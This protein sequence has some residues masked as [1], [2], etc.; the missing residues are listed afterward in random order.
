MDSDSEDGSAG[1]GDYNTEDERRAQASG[2]ASPTPTPSRRRSSP[3][4]TVPASTPTVQ[5]TLPPTNPTSYYKITLTTLT[6]SDFDDSCCRDLRNIFIST[7]ASML[8]IETG[9]VSILSVSESGRRSGVS[10]TFSVTAESTA[11]TSLKGQLEETG[12]NGF[13]YHFITACENQGIV[14]SVSQS[15]VVQQVT[16]EP[17]PNQSGDSNTGLLIGVICAALFLVLLTIGIAFW[18]Y[19]QHTKTVLATGTNDHDQIELVES[20][21]GIQMNP[22]VPMLGHQTKGISSCCHSIS[23]PLYLTTTLSHY[24]SILRYHSF[25]HCHFGLDCRFHETEALSLS[26]CCLP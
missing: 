11:L 24:H 20:P 23:L 8:G 9:S 14:L 7:I 26:C 4:P 10:L 2:S 19:I 17:N 13:G 22:V 18:C 21:I 16:I 3:V 1:S 15:T 25:S 12:T 5:P 6:S